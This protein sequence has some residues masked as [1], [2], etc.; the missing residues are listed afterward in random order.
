MEI[1]A[2][3]F[4]VETSVMDGFHGA[5]FLGCFCLKKGHIFFLEKDKLKIFGIL[6]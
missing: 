2:M 3:G 6:N 4:V 5:S 1:Y